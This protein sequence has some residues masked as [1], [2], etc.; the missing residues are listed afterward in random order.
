LSIIRKGVESGGDL[1]VEFLDFGEGVDDV[2]FII[3][4]L[5]IDFKGTSTTLS[6]VRKEGILLLE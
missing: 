3:D 4:V 2:I 1:F 5:W 6:S